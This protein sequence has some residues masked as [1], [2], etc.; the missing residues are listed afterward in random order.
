MFM[1][2]VQMRHV[3]SSQLRSVGPLDRNCFELRIITSVWL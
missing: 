1:G 3:I 2:S